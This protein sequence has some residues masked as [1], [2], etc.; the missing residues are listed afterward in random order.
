MAIAS[1]EILL[2]SGGANYATDVTPQTISGTTSTDT[3]EIRVNDS[4]AGV[5]YTSGEAV[6]AWTGDLIMGDNVVCVVA[7]EKITLIPSIAA[8]ITITLV[9]RDDFIT[10]SQPTG[11]SVREYQNQMEIVNAQ[12]PEP[13]TLGYNYWVSLQSGGNLG[14]YVKINKQL[15]NS[16]TF[17]EDEV[18]QL[19]KSIDTAGN[20]RVTTTTDE[21]NRAYFYSQYFTQARYQEMVVAGH[22]PAATFTDTTP[23]FFVVTAVIYD[24]ILGQVTESPNSIEME[25]SPISITTG[26]RDLPQ[27]NQ[28]DII[29]TFS[30]ELL[31]NNAGT[32]T[33]PGTVV[34][35]IIDPITE[36]F[37]RMYIIQNF[38]S[39]SL[40]ISGLL[41]FDDANG[42]GISDPVSESLPKQAL[43]L[44]LNLSD[45]NDLQQIIDDQFD[46]LAS[47][48]NET[49]RG[50]T[51]STGQALFYIVQPPIR[52]MTIIEGSIVTS[53]GDLDQGIPSQNYQTL[54]TKVLEYAN[55]DDYYNALTGRYEINVDIESLNDG[56]RGNTDSY[57]IKSISSGADSD[58]SVENPLPVSFGRD[59]ESNYELATRI[60][61]AFFADTGTEGGY[62]KVA[63]NVPGV[64]R[65][66]V[67]KAK[68]PL[69]M[70]DYDDVRNKHVGGKVDVYIQGSL[71]KQVTDQIAF[72]F[73]SIGQSLGTQEG[74]IF[75][76]INVAAYQFKSTNT[77]VTAHTPIFDVTRVYNST[78]A[79]EYDISGYQIIGDGNT[80]DL[81]ETKPT[82]VAIGLV[83]SD[84]IRVDYKF[85]SSDTFVLEH[86][87]VGEIISVIGQISG[88]LTTDN[89]ELV[90]LEDTLQNGNST[91]ASDGIR[92]KYANDLPAT[93][94]QTITDEPHVMILGKQEFLDFVG[95]DPESIIVKSTDKTVKYVVNVDY[96]ILPGTDIEATALLIIESGNIINGQQVLISYNALE[97]FTVTY[98][99]NAVLESVQK[100]ITKFKHACADA[101]A[102][103]AI[104]NSVDIAI[105]VIPKYG[106]TDLNKLT[107]KINTAVANFINQLQIGK[108]LTQSDVNYVIRK[109]DDV[110]YVVIPFTRMVKADGSFI[111]RDFVGETQ[112]EVYNESV[113]TAYITTAVVLSYNTLDKGGDENLFRGIF[114]NSLPL[115]LQDDPLDVSGGAG[116]GYIQSD[117]T[118][119]VSTKDGQLP[120][121]KSYEVAYYVYGETGSEDINVAS[122]EHLRVGTFTIVY[123]EPRNEAPIL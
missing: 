122:I 10:V 20:I 66:R 84:V 68:D 108:S 56:E 59:E 17:Y 19:S 123:D 9:S 26:I 54:T 48:A 27:R 102:K 120:D 110:D 13:N 15:V 12:N 107:S 55:R 44:A 7:I 119:V 71:D 22:L 49:R 6:W 70:R 113:T 74:E 28:T 60:M 4:L 46:K 41:D 104:E 94:F 73:E 63:A 61:L 88:T 83:T 30:Q 58:F 100:N 23:F 75:T 97:N 111:V 116:R 34:R 40:S 76:I 52:N 87:P 89:Y 101:V 11:I 105:T 86:Q 42:D 45:S 80:I 106:V 16:Y 14:T 3:K 98:T 25:A 95:A 51:A 72:S 47:N 92:I 21:I 93:G 77:R 103:N 79:K 62:A 38:L 53:V 115:V 82:N 1:P 35:D 32:D 64:R 112:W 36:E 18:T 114:E 29:L 109:I 67:E 99:T 5:S 39:R 2:P 50:A 117:G 65:V 96:R 43:Q 33:K 8:T 37:A 31:V 91:I 24:P 78:R 81:D 57:T 90:K 121:T 69:M 85:R 118:I